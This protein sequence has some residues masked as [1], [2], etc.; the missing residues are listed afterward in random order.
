MIKN[1]MYCTKKSKKDTDFEVKL[2]TQFTSF[3]SQMA[4]KED[5][6]EELD[7]VGTVA[8]GSD[9]SQSE[10]DEE[11]TE[12]EMSR[13]IFE[14]VP[15]I[16]NKKGLIYYVTSYDGQCYIKEINP[17]HDEF[18]DHLVVY[19]T[20]SERCNGFGSSEGKNF[21]FLDAVNVITMLKQNK[22]TKL[23]YEVKILSIKDKDKPNFKAESFMDVFVR[24]K[25]MITQSE[26]FYLQD[27]NN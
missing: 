8:S 5:K 20:K 21:F 17:K 24:D 19:E 13:H 14:K 12:D 27:Q 15:I 18:D 10:D 2:L 3:I 1:I 11:E 4:L 22:D 9:G 7:E 26:I 25:Y 6:S 16:L 23:F